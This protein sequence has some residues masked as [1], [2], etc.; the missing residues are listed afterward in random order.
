[1]ANYNIYNFNNSG[2]N[3]DKENISTSNLGSFVISTV[4]TWLHL[5][6]EYAHAK[7]YTDIVGDQHFTKS[8][9][10][11]TSKIFKS[12]HINWQC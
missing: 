4:E 7:N 11:S 9:G 10:E 3:S 12:D 6:P 2:L 5:L 8:Y 1:M